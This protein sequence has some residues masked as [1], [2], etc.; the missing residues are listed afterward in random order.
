[1]YVIIAAEYQIKMSVWPVL[2]N[3]GDWSS[4]VLILFHVETASIVTRLVVF[5]RRRT[6]FRQAWKRQEKLGRLSSL[7]ASSFS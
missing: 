6:G 1:M 7:L 3:S 5:Q 2:S 4:K